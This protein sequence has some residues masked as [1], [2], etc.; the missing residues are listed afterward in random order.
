MQSAAESLVAAF[1]RMNPARELGERI[2]E[3]V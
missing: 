3:R 1:R 2:G